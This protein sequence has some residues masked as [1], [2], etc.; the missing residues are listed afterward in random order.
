MASIVRRFEAIRAR[1]E[2][3]AHEL[4]TGG[5]R[6]EPGKSAL[7][8]TRRAVEG[9]WRATNN[10]LKTQGLYDLA[11]DVRRFAE[12]MPPPMTEKEHLANALLRTGRK[13]RILDQFPQ[14]R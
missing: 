13:A 12:Q 3:V 14:T 4:R 10:I 5:V 9:G 2:A 1:V 11:A 6:I 8:E 7:T